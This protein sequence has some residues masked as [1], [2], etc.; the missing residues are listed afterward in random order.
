MIE[1]TNTDIDLID[2]I[3]LINNTEQVTDFFEQVEI[4][5]YYPLIQGRLT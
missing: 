1:T 4:D 2:F 3:D 5:L